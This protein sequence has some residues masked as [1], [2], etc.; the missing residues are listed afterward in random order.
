MINP[1]KQEE[2]K[3]VSFASLQMKKSPGNYKGWIIFA[4]LLTLALFGLYINKYQ[5]LV[6]EGSYLADEHCLKVNPLIIERKNKYIDQYNLMLASAST[7]EVMDAVDKYF[8]A[9]QAYVEEE[10]VWL[11]KQRKFLDSK[12]VNLLMPSY[13]K[14]VAKYQYE[15]YEAEYNISLLLNQEHAELAKDQQFELTNKVMEETAKSKEAED[16]YNAVW[17]REK[18]NTE[19]RYYFVKVPP[20]KCPLE[21][22]NIPQ[23]PNPF[24]PSLIPRSPLS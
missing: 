9:S 22:F 12:M 16:K 17:E 20:S 13:F 19:W 8:K 24:A 18:G 11:A 21:N 2:K 3:P 10:K 1:F 6:N 7:Q 15:K 14:E 5:Q 23:V 4:F